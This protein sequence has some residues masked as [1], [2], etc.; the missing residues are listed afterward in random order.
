MIGVKKLKLFMFFLFIL[1]YV[2]AE[3]WTYII[4][5]FLELSYFIII[6]LLFTICINCGD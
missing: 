2:F 1:T 3:I 4:I 6:E 5:M